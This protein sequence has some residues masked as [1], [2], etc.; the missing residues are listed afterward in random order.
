MWT[1][2]FIITGRE[3]RQNDCGYLSARLAQVDSITLRR[4]VPVININADASVWLYPDL[5][6]ARFQE[7]K[8]RGLLRLINI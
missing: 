4:P 1:P 8:K 5:P 6:L 3:R 2:A 7:G